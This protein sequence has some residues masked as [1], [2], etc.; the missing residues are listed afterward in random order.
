M[1]FFLRFFSLF[2]FNYQL[3]PSAGVVITLA[4]G[5]LLYRRQQN[6]TLGLPGRHFPN[7]HWIVV[8]RA[9]SMRH[10]LCFMNALVLACS[11]YRITGLPT[12]HP[13]QQPTEQPSQQPSRQPSSQPTRQPIMQPTGNCQLPFFLQCPYSISISC[14]STLIFFIGLR[15]FIPSS[16]F[17]ILLNRFHL[18]TTIWLPDFLSNVTLFKYSTHE[19]IHTLGCSLLITVL[20]QLSLCLSFLFYLTLWLLWAIWYAI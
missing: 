20:L 15:R 14:W 13:S 5:N 17:C 3:R 11:T 8:C 7:T 1:S 19:N 2:H 12:S 9:R 16:A 6:S 4:V 10:K 18:F